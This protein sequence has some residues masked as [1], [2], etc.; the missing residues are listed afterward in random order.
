MLADGSRKCAVARNG[1]WGFPIGSFTQADQGK[2]V[3][4]SDDGTITLT[5]TGNLWIGR[6]AEVD[7]VHVWVNIEEAA[8]ALSVHTA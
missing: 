8:G 6:V 5:A 7:T 2:L 4:A 1:L 3:F